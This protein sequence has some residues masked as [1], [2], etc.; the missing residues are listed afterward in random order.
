L[1]KTKNKKQKNS[2]SA[3]LPT[4]P[5]KTPKT[6]KTEN[7]KTLSGTDLVREC[8]S[9]FDD[10]LV[11]PAVEG[12]AAHPEVPEELGENLRREE[13]TVMETELTIS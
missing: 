1:G 13:G 7:V 8:D 10:L 6:K 2:E 3:Q 5:P 12:H 11:V 4:A 9:R